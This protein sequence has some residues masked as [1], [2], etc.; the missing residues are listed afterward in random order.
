MTEGR[1]PRQAG[2]MK[3]ILAAAVAVLTLPLLNACSAPSRADEADDLRQALAALPGVT[4]AGLDYTEPQTLDSG[5]LELRVAMAADARPGDVVLVAARAY[6]AFAGPHHGEEGDLFVTIG[7]DTVHLRSFDPE[8]T[9]AAVKKAAQDATTVLSDGVVRADITTQD[10][11]ASPH[12]FT[13]YTV[14]IGENDGDSVLRTM[15][16]LEKAH[17]DHPRAGWRVR[18]AEDETGWELG[19]TTGFPSGRQRALYGDLRRA[20]PHGGSI[21]L[22]ND[23]VTARTT[24]AVTPDEASAMVRRHVAALGGVEKAFYDVSVGETLA[25]T[26]G[27]GE[28]AFTKDP[29]GQR[30]EHDHGADCTKVSHAGK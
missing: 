2:A 27:E 20:L 19:S 5:K 10:V 8:A 29:V 1:L 28:C 11:A 13:E 25:M 22:V 14:T 12:V 18:T 23:L 21:Q 17:V 7:D 6:E 4:R 24:A 16:Q 15:S 9:M 26:V 3:R 30:L